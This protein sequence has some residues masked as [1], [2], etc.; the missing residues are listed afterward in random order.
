[1][2]SD[3]TLISLQ[4]LQQ[5]K[6]P[7]KMKIGQRIN[8]VQV[9]A[10]VSISGYVLLDLYFHTSEGPLKLGVEAYVVKGMST[11][12]ILGTDFADQYRISMIRSEGNCSLEF[13]NPRRRVSVENSVSP[14]FTDE[15]E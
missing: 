10:N 13:G 14:P 15:E 6:V 9:T 12:M 4:T 7:S 2:G 11:P 8:L 5:L 3:I 1:L